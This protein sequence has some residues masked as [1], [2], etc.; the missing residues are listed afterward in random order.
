MR[1]EDVEQHGGRKQPAVVLA[2]LDQTTAAEAFAHLRL[3]FRPAFRTRHA[4]VD[5][6]G[7]A[8]DAQIGV[9]L[10][11]G[12]VDQLLPE[13]DH[14]VGIKPS[15]PEIR[16]FWRGEAQRAAAD[17]GIHVEAGR[18][19][20]H[21]EV[22]RVRFGCDV[23]ARLMAGESFAEIRD[24]GDEPVGIGIVDRAEVIAAAQIAVERRRRHSAAPA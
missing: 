16:G 8:R 4:V 1:A 2:E 17:M 24:R 20:C 19:Q 10:G 11:T 13:R 9:P 14:H 5:P 6:R 15:G 3:V 7:T 22:R 18:A 12:G 21:L 23:H